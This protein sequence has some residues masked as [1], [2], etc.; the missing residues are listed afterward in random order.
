M[1]HLLQ[2][3]FRQTPHTVVIIHDENA[4]AS[5]R[6]RKFGRRDRPTHVRLADGTL[7]IKPYCRAVCRDAFDLGRAAVLFDGDGDHRETKP[8][9]FAWALRREELIKR[10]GEHMIR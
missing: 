9:A 8:T 4:E 6:L 1:A 3:L 2:H 10:P 5:Y 7:Q